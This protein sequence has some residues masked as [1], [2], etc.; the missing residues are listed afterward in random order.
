MLAGWF[1][2]GGDH[3]K[4]DVAEVLDTTGLVKD[5]GFAHCSCVV[6]LFWGRIR[7]P[8]ESV[9]KG[10]GDLKVQSGGVVLT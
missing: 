4:T 6:G 8:G 5:S 9:V 7:R 10:A 2:L 1:A 3:A